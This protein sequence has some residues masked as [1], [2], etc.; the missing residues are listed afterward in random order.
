VLRAFEAAELETERDRRRE[1]LTFVVVG[2]GP[3]GVELAGALAEISRDTLQ[4]DFRNI[5][6]RESNIQ[7]VDMA[8]RVLPGFPPELSDKAE[9]RLVRLGVRPRTGVEV[10]SID[11]EGLIIGGE[12]GDQRIASR[13]VLWGAG[14]RAA[15]LG[16]ALAKAAG[17]DTDKAGRLQVE[18][19][20]SL[21]GHRQVFVIGDMAAHQSPDGEFL[22]GLAPVAMQQGAYVGRLI[23]KRLRGAEPGPFHYLDKGMLATIGRKSAVASFGKF[24]FNGVLA[25]LAWLFVHLLYLVGFQNRVLVATQWAFHY[26]TYNR[27]ARIIVEDSIEHSSP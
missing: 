20:C 16:R 4:G 21:P 13:T 11:A 3:T 2:A 6:P 17:T 27:R 24:H 7:L 19:D 10:K 12:S 14:V 23:K 18:S 8:P 15:P 22:P 26:F 1:W 25:W 9:E 5:E